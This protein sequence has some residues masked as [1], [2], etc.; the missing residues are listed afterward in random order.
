MFM[1]FLYGCK[2]SNSSANQIVGEKEL[3]QKGSY[4]MTF[5]AQG[6]EPGWQAIITDEQVIYT[7]INIK[8]AIIYKNVQINPIM[9]VAGIRYSAV[10]ENGDRITVQVFKEKCDDSMADK[11]WTYRTSVALN[12]GANES[13]FTGCGEFIGDQ[14]LNA[15][16]LIQSYK[17][18]PVPVFNTNKKPVVTFNTQQNR[19]NGNMGCNGIG[20][21]YELMENKIY[22]D[23]NFMSTQ[24]YCEEVMELEKDFTE[25]IS[26]KTLKYSF[27]ENSLVFTNLEGVVVM[28]LIKE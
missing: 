14:R 13:G 26:G 2:S 9:D 1:V 5:I 20:G 22:F 7:S 6:N 21:G 19:V 15:T 11:V 8:G 3:S 25:L 12:N 18:N 16:W 4:H 10:S 23:S 27:V 28:T 17:G 24:M